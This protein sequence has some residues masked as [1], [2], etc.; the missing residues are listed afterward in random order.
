MSAS[1]R[2]IFAT[3]ALL[4]SGSLACHRQDAPAVE[5]PAAPPPAARVPDDTHI[6]TPEE[7]DLI[8]VLRAKDESVGDDMAGEAACGVDAEGAC[9]AEGSCGGEASCASAPKQSPPF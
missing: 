3:L 7:E 1:R 8:E 5:V 9:G 4:G 6:R 2:R